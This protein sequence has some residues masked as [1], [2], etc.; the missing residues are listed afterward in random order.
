MSTSTPLTWTF[1]SNI[2]FNAGCINQLTG[3]NTPPVL[4]EIGHPLTCT[5]VVQDFQSGSGVNV[6]DGT[7]IVWSTSNASSDPGVGMFTC[8]SVFNISTDPNCPRPSTSN[9]ATFAQCFTGVSTPHGQ[10]SVVYRRL[11]DST[12]GGVG[13]RPIL[14]I[15]APGLSTARPFTYNDASGSKIQVV[16]QS[17]VHPAQLFVNCAA[18]SP[19]SALTQSP[20]VGLATFIATI[21]IGV[22]ERPTKSVTCNALVLDATANPALA[23]MPDSNLAESHPPLG[24]V[25]VSFFDGGDFG[26]LNPSSPSCQLVRL[27]QPDTSS[28]NPQSPSRSVVQ[29]TGQEPFMAQCTLP[30]FKANV[31]AKPTGSGPGQIPQPYLTFSYDGADGAHASA[32]QIINVDYS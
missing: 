21:E 15:A 7:Q 20:N 10:C 5:A 6:P 24:S 14:T 17:D 3:Q 27:D 18:T 31:T 28:T 11:F 16:P 23:A 13:A 1:I 26:T 32:T 22:H 19:D 30:A 29:P 12:R 25:T 4:V 8:I 2:V 9:P